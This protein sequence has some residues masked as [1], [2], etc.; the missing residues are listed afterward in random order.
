MNE[1]GLEVRNLPRPNPAVAEVMRRLGT[2]AGD[3]RGIRDE[4]AD[5]Q[6]II[7][8]ESMPLAQARR[9]HTTARDL[10]KDVLQLKR[11]AA[12]LKYAAGGSE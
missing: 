3:V 10:E 1:E 8:Q 5:I 4:L 9:L 2:L 11:A 12:L 6:G 7:A